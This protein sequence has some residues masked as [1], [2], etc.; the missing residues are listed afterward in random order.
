[1][2][3][4]LRQK[5]IDAIHQTIIAVSE[6]F[7]IN[8]DHILSNIPKKGKGLKSARGIL[9]HHLHNN[10]MSIESISR[11]VKRSPDSVR[12]AKHEAVI[13]MQPEEAALIASLPSI[14]KSTTSPI[15]REG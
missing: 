2:T 7:Q 9:V 8:P 3:T 14:P 6:F 12:A 13:R 4:T 10:G 15:G 11:L 5:R 1:M